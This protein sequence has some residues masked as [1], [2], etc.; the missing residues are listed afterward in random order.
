MQTLFDN[1]IGLGL[2]PRGYGVFLTCTHIFTAGADCF[3]FY[4]PSRFLV[5]CLHR[6]GI[7]H[8]HIERN[9][10]RIRYVCTHTFPFARTTMSEQ[11]SH[12]SVLEA[13]PEV[14]SAHHQHHDLEKQ[15]TMEGEEEELE[16]IKENY[17]PKSTPPGPPPILE[18][19]QC[20]S[21][22]LKCLNDRLANASSKLIIFRYRKCWRI[23]KMSYRSSWRV[24]YRK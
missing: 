24:I 15:H 2:L 23:Y 19:R 22:L 4:P 21:I 14:D 7:T 3:S 13:I 6:Y 18:L 9:L 8:R 17:K 16:R 5:G 12:Q 1:H 20:K 11:G 10:S